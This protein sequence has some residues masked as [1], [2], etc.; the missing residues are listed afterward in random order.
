MDE[1]VSGLDSYTA[2]EVMEVVRGLIDDG[3]SLCATLHS[4]TPM[5]FR[6]FDRI[7]LLVQ[8]TMVFFGKRGTRILGVL[9]FSLF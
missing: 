7:I 5:T 1:P 2:N 4:P 6:L 9:F 3:V 8:G